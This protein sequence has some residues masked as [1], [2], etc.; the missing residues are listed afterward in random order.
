MIRGI[1][2]DL[3]GVVIDSEPLYQKVEIKLFGE[4]GIEIPDKDWKLFRGCTEE[5]FYTLSME[6]FQIQ[7]DRETFMKKG[8]NYLFDEF[9]NSL[10]FNTGFIDLINR[11]SGKFKSGLVTASPASVFKYI[12]QKLNINQFFKHIITAEDT[13]RS[14][15]HPDPYLKMMDIMKI[16]PEDTIIIED[17][18]H[19]MNSAISAGGIVVGL[20]G[21]VP[22]EDMPNPNIVI[23]TLDELTEEII[24]GLISK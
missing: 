3:D 19:G 1:I 16:P 24:Q 8:R 9:D 20:T 7:E 14:K 18:I 5:D 10:E 22:I 13:E 4:Y 23:E 15:P 17:S 12:D 21:S 11:I 2:F 6:R